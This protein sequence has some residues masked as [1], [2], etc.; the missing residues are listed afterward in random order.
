MSA[1]SFSPRTLIGNVYHALKPCLLCCPPV[2][3]LLSLD[4]I[5]YALAV[6]GCVFMHCFLRVL[7]IVVLMIPLI[8][9]SR[10]KNFLHVMLELIRLSYL[11]QSLPGVFS[12]RQAIGQRH[13]STHC[14]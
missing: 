1:S 14:L 9:E 11:T 4:G 7:P 6:L 3:L 5:E 13:L 12:C 2:T 10:L 8:E